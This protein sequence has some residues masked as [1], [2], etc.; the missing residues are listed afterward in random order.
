M[1]QAAAYTQIRQALAGHAPLVA[2]VSG[3]IRPDR[4]EQAEP[5]PFV[6]YRRASFEEQR[7]LDGTLFGTR[8]TFQVEAWD[9][10]RAGSLDVAEVCLQ[11]LAAAPLMT[12]TSDPD[13][14]DPASGVLAVTINVD[15]WT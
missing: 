8:H 15:V 11:A 6:V 10:T 7:G 3:R 5:F 14:Y 4:V 1:T 12:S 9:K 13:A 2:M